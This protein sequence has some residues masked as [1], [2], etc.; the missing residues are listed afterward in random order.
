MIIG[1]VL[2][3]WLVVGVAFFGWRRLKSGKESGMPR[4]LARSDD[5]RA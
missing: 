2:G 3:F 4:V 1:E 5:R